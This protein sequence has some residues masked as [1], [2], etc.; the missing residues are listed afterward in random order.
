M[1]CRATKVIGTMKIRG[2]RAISPIFQA[3]GSDECEEVD[4]DEEDLHAENDHYEDEEEW[5]AVLAATAEE[6]SD[7]EG[8]GSEV[9][10]SEGFPHDDDQMEIDE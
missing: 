2:L 4:D 3:M 1:L 7:I 6:A 8:S 9:T 10:D 5:Q